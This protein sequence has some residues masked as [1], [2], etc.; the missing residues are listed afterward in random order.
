[1]AMRRRPKAPQRPVPPR[2]YDREYDYD[3]GRPEPPSSGGGKSGGLGSL[4]NS[5]VMAV[6]AG[7]LVLGIGLGIAIS[8]TASLSPEN[9]ASREVIDRSVPNPQLCVQYGASAITVDM[10]AFV[11]L[12][13]FNVYVSQPIMQPGCVMRSNNMNMLERTQKVSPEELRLCKNRMN[14]LAFTG[15]IEAKESDARV[16]CVYQN[17]SARNLFLNVPGF[18]DAT[19]PESDRF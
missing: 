11:T 4:L 9:V 15:D 12:N 2:D 8:S 16:D 19:R 13:P 1:M 14:T 17:N 6:L 5:T 10:R 7:V 18:R 3:Y